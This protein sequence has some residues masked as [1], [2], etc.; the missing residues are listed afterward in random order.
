MSE[1]LP[2][3]GP[4]DQAEGLRR[5]LGSQPIELTVAACETELIDAYA[6]IKR[7]AYERNCH[8]FKV[9]ISRARSAEQA[10]NVFDSLQRVAREYLGVRLEYLGM[11]KSEG[12]P[13]LSAARSIRGGAAVRSR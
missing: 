7:I 9:S 12:T 5:L 11:A 6:R 3:P 8:H 13:P 10:R 4:G 1:Q 2:A